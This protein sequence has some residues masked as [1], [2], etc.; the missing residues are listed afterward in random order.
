MGPDEARQQFREE[1]IRRALEAFLKAGG[2]RNPARSMEEA[3][4][5][6]D[7]WGAADKAAAH[8]GGLWK[9]AVGDALAEVITPWKRESDGEFVFHVDARNVNCSAVAE[10][11]RAALASTSSA[12][13]RARQRP[14]KKAPF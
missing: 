12:V 11:M 9:P 2:E 8:C 1:M 4:T 13:I 5:A 6:V 3:L 7:F 14:P 10:A